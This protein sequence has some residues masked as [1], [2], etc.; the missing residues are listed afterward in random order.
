VTHIVAEQLFDQSADLALLSEDTLRDPLS[1]VLARADEVARPIA[2]RKGP[3]PR[4]ESAHHPR[5]LRVIPK[6]RDFH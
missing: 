5:D 3:G 1:G 6:S 4:R 2:E